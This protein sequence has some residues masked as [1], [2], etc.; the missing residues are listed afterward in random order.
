[1]SDTTSFVTEKT[2]IEVVIEVL[3]IVIFRDTSR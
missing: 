3:L 2:G 1:L